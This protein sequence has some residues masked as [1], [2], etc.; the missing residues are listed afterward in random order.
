MNIHWFQEP[1][2]VVYMQAESFLPKLGI[3]KERK[4]SAPFL[5]HIPLRV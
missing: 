1:E 2:H 4:F 3:K 5:C